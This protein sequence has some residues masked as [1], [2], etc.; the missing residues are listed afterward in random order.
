MESRFL[1]LSKRY[2]SKRINPP[3]DF[4]HFLTE[5]IDFKRSD[6]RLNLTEAE[7]AFLINA[8]GY[9]VKISLG[10]AMD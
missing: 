10:L 6:Q 8:E 1:R 7:R 3:Q 9:K 4:K 2:W 5:F